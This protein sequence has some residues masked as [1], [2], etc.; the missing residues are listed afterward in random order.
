MHTDKNA[1]ALYVQVVEAGSFSKAAARAGVPVSTISRK[2]ADL[3]KALRVRLL[4]RSTRQ[5]R[6]TEIGRGY[7]ELCRRGLTEF[8]AA[9]SLVTQ[10]QAEISGRLRISIPPSM[11][12]LAIVPLVSAFQER[13]PKATVHCLVT[14]RYIDYIADGIDLSLRVEQPS[15]R[16]SNVVA[17]TMTVHRP[18]LLASPTYMARVEPITRLQ[19]V[20]PHVHIAFSRWEQPV[21]WRLICGDASVR[22]E[23]E[24]RLVIND[25][26]GVLQGLIDGLGVSELPSFLCKAALREGRLVEV[27]PE[28]QFAGVKVAAAFPSN[29]YLSPLVRAFKDFCAT[30][31]ESNPLA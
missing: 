1:M 4:E 16:D 13:Y 24:P 23:L 26:A 20:V 29:R 10:R 5:L 15:N 25:Y 27:L 12:D 3:E 17:S 19:D 18:R 2:I 9:D 28:W 11:S 7:F 22:I 14:E 6:M 21:A 31:F 8:E 30:Y